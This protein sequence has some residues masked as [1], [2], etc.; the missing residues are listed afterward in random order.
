MQFFLFSFCIRYLQQYFNI[1]TFITVHYFFRYRYLFFYMRSCSRL[2]M[3]QEEEEGGLSN[4]TTVASLV[5]QA[6]AAAAAQTQPTEPP[7]PTA[8]ASPAKASKSAA[9]LSAEW[10]EEEKEEEEQ[11]TVNG[12]QQATEKPAEDTET[13]AA[14]MVVAAAKEETAEKREEGQQQQQGEDTITPRKSGRQPKPSTKKVESEEMEESVDAIAKELERTSSGPEG[15]A[16]AE[17]PPP[18]AKKTPA[19]SPKSVKGGKRGKKQWVQMIFGGDGM[20]GAASSVLASCSAANASGNSETGMITVASVLAPES[21]DQEEVDGKGKRKG[22][23]KKK[24]LDEKVSNSI[25]LSGRGFLQKVE[26]N[27]PHCC[28]YATFLFAS[29]LRENL[30][31]DEFE[32]GNILCRY[33]NPCTDPPIILIRVLDL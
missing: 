8:A 7:P 27:V 10:E 33:P 1:F 13:A 11:E 6:E 31:E 12:E 20:V 19:K 3:F 25:L 30:G 28:G 21:G 29:Y 24:D 16:A 26:I 18:R 5:D 2:E 17:T 32:P 23:P 15:A 22:R 14:A 9:E 4:L